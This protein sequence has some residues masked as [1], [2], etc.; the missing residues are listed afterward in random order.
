M[1][2]VKEEAQLKELYTAGVD[3]KEIANAVGKSER[4]VISKLVALK[5]Y[6]PKVK[7]SKVTGGAPKT[8]AAYVAEVEVLLDVKLPDLE[9]APKT[10]LIALK[11]S[12]EEW[13]GAME[14]V[15]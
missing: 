14:D 4:S 2:T 5:I 10:T 13:F 12:L 7:A 1:Y 3:V 11:E 9:K 15:E 6:V 8:K